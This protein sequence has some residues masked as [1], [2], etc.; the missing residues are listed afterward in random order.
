M[1]PVVV[2]QQHMQKA[3]GARHELQLKVTQLEA[4]VGRGTLTGL[5]V[6]SGLTCTRT[7]YNHSLYN[8]DAPVKDSRL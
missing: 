6:G 5:V 4:E 2:H 3:E 8:K 7:L 1:M